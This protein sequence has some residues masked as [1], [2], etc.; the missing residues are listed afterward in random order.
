MEVV[1][2]TYFYST[3]SAVQN[4]VGHDSKPNADVAEQHNL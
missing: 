2:N 1:I 3:A 4:G